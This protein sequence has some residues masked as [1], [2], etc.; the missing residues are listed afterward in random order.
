MVYV[1]QICWQVSAV[2]KPLCY[3][4][5]R[6]SVKTS[7]WWTE[8]LFETCRV[9]FQKQIWEISA[10]SWFY[11]NNAYGKVSMLAH[12]DVRDLDISLS[13]I[14]MIFFTSRSWCRRVKI[15]SCVYA[16]LTSVIHDVSLITFVLGTMRISVNRLV[17]FLQ[18]F[19]LIKTKTSINVI[20]VDMIRSFYC[21]Y[22]TRSLSERDVVD[23]KWI[24][25][26]SSG[27]YGF[28]RWN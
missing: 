23:W 1:I 24:P 28:I 20:T 26:D 19:V 13:H 21:R 22:W 5:L 9:L 7:W 17:F 6:C 3:I 18:V 10:S 25:L 15:R 12:H 8:E 27:L 4:P 11:Y 2:S 14:L 16:Q